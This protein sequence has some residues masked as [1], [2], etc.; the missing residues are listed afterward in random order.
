MAAFKATVLYA[1]LV[2]N[3]AAMETAIET[4]TYSATSQFVVVPQPGNSCTIIQV[5]TA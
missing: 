1:G 2:T 3:A 4:G 5:E